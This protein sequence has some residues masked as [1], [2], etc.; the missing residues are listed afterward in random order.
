MLA[1]KF[2]PINKEQNDFSQSIQIATVSTHN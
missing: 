2:T 1:Q